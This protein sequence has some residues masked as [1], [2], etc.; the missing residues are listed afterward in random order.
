MLSPLTGICDPS[1]YFTSCQGQ[2]H[3]TRNLL[4]DEKVKLLIPS[5]PSSHRWKPFKG[6]KGRVAWFLT[7]PLLLILPA[8]KI[9]NQK[10]SSLSF[11]YAV[12][13][14][15]Y[16]ES[17]H[18]LLNHCYILPPLQRQYEYQHRANDSGIFILFQTFLL[19]F[20]IL[21]MYLKSNSS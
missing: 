2:W 1:P 13:L 20:N 7:Q 5:L 14:S 3:N 9:Q 6:L 12:S 10:A 21:N 4:R 16:G 17:F 15:T 19:L 8:S 18:L 11:P